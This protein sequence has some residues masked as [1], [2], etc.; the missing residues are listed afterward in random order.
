MQRKIRN[1]YSK[2]RVYGGGNGSENSDD[3]NDCRIPE[4]IGSLEEV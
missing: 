3:S 2:R 1:Y 4:M